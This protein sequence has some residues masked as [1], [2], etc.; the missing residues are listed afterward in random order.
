MGKESFVLTDKI[1]FVPDKEMEEILWFNIRASA[2]VYNKTLE[3]NGYRENLVKEFGIG[4][5]I[6]NKPHIHTKCH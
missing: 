3:F 5:K 6:Q 1:E 2:Y 4:K